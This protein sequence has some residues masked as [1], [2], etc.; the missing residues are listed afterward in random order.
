MTDGRVDLHD[1]LAA[2]E[3]HGW[4]KASSFQGLCRPVNSEG[5]A[6]G[7]DTIR[8]DVV[9]GRFLFQ[10]SWFGKSWLLNQWPDRKEG[11]AVEV[12][13]HLV[14]RYANEVEGAA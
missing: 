5:V 6:L 7:L 10:E 13:A 1:V 4:R 3:P 11:T 2:L 8:P 14:A 12:L 9:T